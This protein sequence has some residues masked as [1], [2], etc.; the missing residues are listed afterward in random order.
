MLVIAAIPTI[1]MDNEDKPDSELLDPVI[2]YIADIHVSELCESVVPA[3]SEGDSSSL[4][5]RLCN[6][7]FHI[8][9]E[10]VCYWHWTI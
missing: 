7:H 6:R 8:C 1:M 4:H 3:Y 10:N 5:L 2:Y 9:K